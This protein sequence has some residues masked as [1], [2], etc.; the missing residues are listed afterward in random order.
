MNEQIHDRGCGDVGGA[1]RDVLV[2]ALTCALMFFVHQSRFDY[3]ETEG[4]R[5][6]V[7]Y[8]MVERGGPSMPTVHHRS[9]VNKPPLYAWT[10]S[11]LARGLGRFDEQVARLPSAICATLLVLGL[12][13]AGRRWGG[14]SVGRAAAA[15]ALANVTV[16]DY[17]FRAEL[18]MPFTFF[19][20][21]MFMLV[22]VALMRT[23]GVSFAAW[24]GAYVAAT[25]AAMWKAPHSLIFMWLGLLTY[26]RVHRRWRWMI[27]P[28]Q[29]VGLAASMTVLTAWLLAVLK[30]AGGRRV[31]TAAGSEVVHR[32]APG[33]ADLLQVPLF[34]LIVAVVGLPGTLF[35]IASAAEL[36][37]GE[38]S[39]SSSS[40]LKRFAAAVRRWWSA[41]AS[42]PRAEFLLLML[43]PN[44]I[45][46]A[47]APAKSARYTLPLFPLLFLLAAHLM[48]RSRSSSADG[49]APANV[50]RSIT[51]ALHGL[52]VFILGVGAAALIAGTILVVRPQLRI[53]E[54]SLG[55]A[56][57]WF[58]LGTAC[59]VAG[60]F[61]AVTRRSSDARAS[62]IGLVLVAAG[63]KPVMSEVW[64]EAREKS[65][66]QRE[67]AA[68]I[69]AVVPEGEPVFVLGR[70]EF[71]DT[72][73]Y[74][75][76]AFYWIEAPSECR[77]HTNAAK[78]YF[79]MRESE[80]IGD[81][82]G[83]PNFK[84]AT[85]YVERLRFERIDREVIVFQLDVDGGE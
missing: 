35:V 12:Y 59:L 73:L 40:A 8:E 18:D 75:R 7:A 37:T 5:A 69:D 47:I 2:L 17:G 15:F 38:A 10:T 1:A 44:L 22:Y 78:P 66:S 68:R 45:F 11:L 28:G 80:L 55:P 53:G 63:C 67:A 56:G 34:P 32:L 70:Q 49:S 52:W 85:G 83:E 41:A 79:L 20:A 39:A 23:G 58:I 42:D 29:V 4:L 71:P 24:I 27:A 51:A 50:E 6:L 14:A 82:P 54:V 48:M 31:G 74:S 61:Y 33:L 25:A 65:D 3:I 19:V 26:A 13:V 36:A 30:F 9:Y 84:E 57:S 21:L 43:V 76:R 60:G 46:L 81:R 77:P 64:W 62:V 72:A 16:L